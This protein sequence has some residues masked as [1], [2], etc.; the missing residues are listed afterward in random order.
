MMEAFLYTLAIVTIGI[1]C[2]LVGYR[3][4]LVAERDRELRELLRGK[5]Q[6]RKVRG[7][8]DPDEAWPR[9]GDLPVWSYTKKETKDE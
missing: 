8:L 5:T 9:Q 7:W 4:A 6:R 3:T 2:F 1:V